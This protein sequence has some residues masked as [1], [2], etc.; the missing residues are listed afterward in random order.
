M[1]TE[2][3]LADLITDTTD[4]YTA[5]ERRGH[6]HFSGD[7][8]ETLVVSRSTNKVVVHFRHWDNPAVIVDPNLGATGHAGMDW[9]HRPK[10]FRKCRDQEF[11]LAWVIDILHDLD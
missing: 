7:Y 5:Y 6:N 8:L 10:G 2:H 11:V 4:K 3:L 1:S 9:R